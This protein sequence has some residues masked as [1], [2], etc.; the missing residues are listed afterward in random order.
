MIARHDVPHEANLNIDNYFGKNCSANDQPALT[1]VGPH[2]YKL[3]L[4]LSRSRRHYQGSELAVGHVHHGAAQPLQ[5]VHGR[6][7]RGLDRA[8]VDHHVQESSDTALRDS[9]ECE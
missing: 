1:K 6:H 5:Q 8:P 7:R 9:R 4:A 2:G 3:T